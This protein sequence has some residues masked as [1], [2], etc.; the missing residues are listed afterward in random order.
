MT[1]KATVSR[2]SDRSHG[3]ADGGGGHHHEAFDGEPASELG[4]GEPETPLWLPV[5]GLAFFVA[6]GVWWG[7]GDGQADEAGDAAPEAT[8]TVGAAPER[9]KAAPERPPMRPPVRPGARPGG[10]VRP[11]VKGRLDP[12]RLEELKKRMEAQRAGEGRP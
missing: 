8:A 1:D 6:V 11:T 9:P 7:L 10:T 5:V 3:V 4:P 2:E 12:K